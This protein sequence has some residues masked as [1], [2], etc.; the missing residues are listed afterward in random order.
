MSRNWLGKRCLEKGR[1]GHGGLKSLV[2]SPLGTQVSQVRLHCQ[3]LWAGN[4][5]KEQEPGELNPEIKW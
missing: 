5:G 2:M 1:A 3:S 4:L